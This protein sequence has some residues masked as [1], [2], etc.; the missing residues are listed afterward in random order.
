MER[1][2]VLIDPEQ[3]RR[4]ERLAALQRRSAA[5][6][7]R[8]ALDIGLDALEGNDE[9]WE[10]RMK[11]LAEIRKRTKNLP[12]IELDLVGEARKERD[13]EMEQLWRL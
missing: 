13:E 7:L 10:R 9:V 4:L 11:A 3:K 1:Y 2:Q 5:S 6:V 8:Q 12:L